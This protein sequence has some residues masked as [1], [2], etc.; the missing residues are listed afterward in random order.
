M[1]V[2]GKPNIVMMFSYFNFVANSLVHESTS[3]TLAHFVTYSTTVIMYHAPV[4]Q[5]LWPIS[6][7]LEWGLLTLRE[8]HCI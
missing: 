4:L 5:S 3:S 6:Q 2:R 7:M 8:F 1:R